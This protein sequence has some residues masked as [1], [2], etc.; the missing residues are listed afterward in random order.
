MSAKWQAKKLQA[1]IYPQKHYK[2]I[3]RDLIKQLYK[4]SENSQRSTAT[5]EHPVR[6]R[7][8]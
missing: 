8:N 5:K 7:P 6:K 3:T 1:F 2:K 4:R